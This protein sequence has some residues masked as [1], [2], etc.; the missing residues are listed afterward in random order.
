MGIDPVTH[1]P[2]LDFQQLSS[3]LN[4]PLYNSISSPQILPNNINNN[5]YPSLFGMGTN[6]NNNILN[7]SLLSLL[8]ALLSSSSQ[9]NPNLQNQ[10]ESQLP[11][12]P[13]SH[14]QSFQL[15][16]Y[17]HQVEN[18]AT[19]F[20]SQNSVI[21]PSLENQIVQSQSN[22][23][24]NFNLGALL[25]NY[26]TPSSSTSPSTL[27]SSASSTTFVNGN[28]TNNTNT[29]TT[30]DE[31]DTYC[32]NML[33]YNISNGFG[34]NDSGLLWPACLMRVKIWSANCATTL[35]IYIE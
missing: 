31:R 7:P 20:S 19:H 2:C 15:P 14:H 28:S 8:T 1:T 32:S 6:N 10:V 23:H 16:N 24:N 13:S 4:S 18:Q 33:M 26:S 34:I 35:Y 5:N 29:N 25:S 27:N 30:E 9:M 21:M 12:Y 3:I 17:P 22:N 11:N